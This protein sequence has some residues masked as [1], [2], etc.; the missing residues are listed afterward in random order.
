MWKLWWVPTENG[1]SRHC[2][3]KKCENFGEFQLKMW[4]QKTFLKM[5]VSPTIVKNKKCEI[6]WIPTE[7]GESRTCL[8]EL[9]GSLADYFTY[10]HFWLRLFSY[11]I[12]SIFTV[13]YCALVWAGI[14]A[15]KSRAEMGF[16]P[17]S[18]II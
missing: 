1:E 9:Q 4:V 11:I 8:G 18:W 5:L 16:F 7:N 6:W 13:F 2:K 10:C 15:K 14:L 12:C 3:N 17:V